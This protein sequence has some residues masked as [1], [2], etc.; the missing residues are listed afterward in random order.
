MV[1]RREFLFHNPG[2]TEVEIKAMLNNLI[3]QSQRWNYCPGH[4][5]EFI[6]V[7]RPINREF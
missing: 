7:L 6:P 5:M 2:P 3:S 4:V 1:L